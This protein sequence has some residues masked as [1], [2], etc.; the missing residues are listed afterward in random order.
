MLPGD[1]V[2]IRVLEVTAESL[3]QATRAARNDDRPAARR[4]AR[5]RVR[6]DLATTMNAATR[7]RTSTTANGV[8]GGAERRFVRRLARVDRTLDE[9]LGLVCGG[10]VA[11]LATA[12]A[13]DL[14]LLG[15]AGRE[16]LLRLA[17]GLD[18]P[19]VDGDYRR[20]GD[21]LFSVLDHLIARGT[22]PGLHTSPA[23]LCGDLTFAVLGTSRSATAA[24]AAPRPL[25]QHPETYESSVTRPDPRELSELTPTAR[26]RLRLYRTWRRA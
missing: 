5:E 14:E 25:I 1:P 21:E 22:W 23:A 4:L 2:F 16:R 11:T 19:G 13:C 7:I 3:H 18:R 17:A 9:F 10:G 6:L 24:D 26:R 15:H 8:L 12:D 20:C